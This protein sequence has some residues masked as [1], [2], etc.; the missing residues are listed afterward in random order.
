M[1]K[2][3]WLEDIKKLGI[4]INEKQLE[5][6]DAFYNM[7]IEKNKVM[8]LTAITDKKEVYYKHFYD[9]LS[10]IKIVN[11]EKQNKLCDFGSGAGFPGIIL[12]IIFPNLQITLVE[13]QLK[14]VNFLNEVI[15]KLDLKNIEAIHERIEDYVQKN[16]EKFDIIIARAVAKLS[17]LLEWSVKGLK[18]NG[19]FIAMK[20][21][22]KQEISEIKNALNILNM[23]IEK[24]ID[25]ILPEYEAKRCLISIKKLSK[26]N[27]KYPRKYSEIKRRPL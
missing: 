1:D 25:F 9:S 20:T 23:K 10:I 6:L 13:A 15:E 19:S 18:I 5:K 22:S 3:K 21:D 7:L 14:R 16:E 24:S 2:T 27:K 26:T 8:N 11:L 17:I 12:G 4:N